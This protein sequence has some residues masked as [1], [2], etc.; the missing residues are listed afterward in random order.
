MRLLYPE[1]QEFPTSFIVV[2][3][4]TLSRGLT[5]SGLVSTYFLRRTS[6]GD[7]LMQMGRWFG[8]R[9]DYELMPRI[10]MTTDEMRNFRRMA[11]EE[12]DLR[13]SIERLVATG[14]NT[15]DYQVSLLTN[16]WFK[17]TA[18][19]KMQARQAASLDF[20]G[21]NIQTVNFANKRAPLS[22]NI[23]TMETFLKSLGIPSL[24]KRGLKS[25]WNGVNA[26]EIIRF[27]HDLDIS[28]RNRAFNDK[29]LFCAWL[30]KASHDPSIAKWNVIAAGIN[31][32]DSNPWKVG[33]GINRIFRS[34]IKRVSDGDNFSIGTL[35][36][37]ADRF[38]DFPDDY[39]PPKDNLKEAD[40]T[41]ERTRVLG[42]DVPQLIIYRI[43]KDSPAPKRTPKS[44]TEE[45]RAKLDAV[46]DLVGIC[47]LI[48]GERRR[49]NPVDR[50]TV[51]RS[52]S[53]AT[54]I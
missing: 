36:G 1:K 37:P 49:N 8:Y 47:L 41:A 51:R 35:L 48:P 6:F 44:G 40:V 14:G 13:Q 42:S 16:P 28:E 54:V 10:W 12:I 29:K 21:S 2:G 22:K 33:A 24:S 23:Q 7:T 46:E 26:G 5:L 31:R 34:K 45:V 20:S 11:Y 18:P 3:G 19:N 39:K 9:I 32:S 4:A 15:E 27:I 52:N 25:V 53:A 17:P 38:L 30:K 43:D 50:L